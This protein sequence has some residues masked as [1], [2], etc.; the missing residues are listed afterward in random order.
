M[1]SFRLRLLMPLACCLHIFDASKSNPIRFLIVSTPRRSMIA[2]KRIGGSS[3]RKV[4]DGMQPLITAGLVHP[5]GIAVDHKRSALLVADPDSRRIFSYPLTSTETT[6]KAG[7]PSVIAENTEA[8][9]VSV[10]GMGNVYFTDEPQNKILKVAT[11]N[12]SKDTTPTVVYDGVSMVQVSAPGGVAVDG[13]HAYWVNKQTG[14]QVGSLIQASTKQVRGSSRQLV[15]ALSK[16][17][18]KSYGVCLALN[19]IYFTQPES[20]LIGVKKMS[21]DSSTVISN[22]L[23]NP[24]GC[25]WDGDGTVFVAD[26]GANA[27]MAFPSNMK[28]MKSVELYKV[29]D[30][31][32]AFGVAVYS[33][34]S[35]LHQR[36]A[37][38]LLAVAFAHHWV[39]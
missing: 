26:R 25:A 24:R 23:L 35:S 2:Y 10:D 37:L 33:G 21:V 16:H 17:V 12:V 4:P 7:Q 31:E 3:L 27:V 8:R 32:D 30:F 18:D 34:A 36:G 6:L 11:S 28:Y 20:T 22:R 19:N 15:G 39:T 38:L 9:W 13:F 1:A 14:T 5:Q 29:A